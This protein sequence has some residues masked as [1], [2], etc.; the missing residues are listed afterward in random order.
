MNALQKLRQ[1]LFEKLKDLA[2]DSP[3]WYG[4]W[5]RIK[6]LDEVIEVKGRV[7][8]REPEGGAG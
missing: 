2:E 6:A 5:V 1:E 8:G 7:I 4:L 3:E